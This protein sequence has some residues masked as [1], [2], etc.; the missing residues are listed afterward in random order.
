M[1]HHQVTTP[2]EELLLD[3]N[4]LGDAGLRCLE[5]PSKNEGQGTTLREGRGQFFVKFLKL[6]RQRIGCQKC[7]KWGDLVKKNLC[8]SA[9]IFFHGSEIWLIDSWYVDS[10]YPSTVKIYTTCQC[11]A[12]RET[13]VAVMYGSCDLKSPRWEA[14]KPLKMQSTIGLREWLEMKSQLVSIRQSDN[15]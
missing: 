12:I 5:A 4:A 6:H 15:T 9:W 2:L 7:P 13:Y 8:R 10:L 11:H 14:R 1:A 3:D